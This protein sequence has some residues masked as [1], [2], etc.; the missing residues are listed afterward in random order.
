MNVVVIFF[1]DLC[2]T[3]SSSLSGTPYINEL[4][5]PNAVEE[6]DLLPVEVLW[7][8]SSFSPLRTHEGAFRNAFLPYF[9]FPLIDA[10]LLDYSASIGSS[11]WLIYVK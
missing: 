10:Y 4:V 9:S 2:L 11:G 3:L 6:L 8:P 1:A 7:R 5:F